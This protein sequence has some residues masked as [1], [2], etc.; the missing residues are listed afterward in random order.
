MEMFPVFGAEMARIKA[1]ELVRLAASHQRNVQLRPARAP[2]KPRRK[3]HVGRPLAALLV[4]T[5]LATPA[6]EVAAR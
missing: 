4:G 1:D 3:L 2:R 6:D 5:R